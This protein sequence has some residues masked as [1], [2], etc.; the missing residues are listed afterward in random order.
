MKLLYIDCNDVTKH[1]VLQDVMEH[2]VNNNKKTHTYTYTHIHKNTYIHTHTYTYIHTYIYTH[3]HTQKYTHI[4]T[5]IHT[6]THTH[7]HTYASKG[8][9]IFPALTTQTKVYLY[10][11]RTFQQK[12]N[13]KSD[14]KLHL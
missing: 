12:S 1:V 14:T 11:E 8:S 7:I 13:D 5:Y 3:T 9:I 10:A 4:H 2:T 6:H